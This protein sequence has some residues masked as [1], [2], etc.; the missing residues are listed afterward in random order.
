MYKI[1]L[2][3]LEV[4]FDLQGIN[5]INNVW[6]IIHNGLY[7][8]NKWY[9]I[10]W[11]EEKLAFALLNTLPSIDFIIIDKIDKYKIVLT[12]YSFSSFVS[13]KYI[14]M[15]SFFLGAWFDI[16]I[17]RNSEK[18]NLLCLEDNEFSST[19]TIVSQNIFFM[20]KIAS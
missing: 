8:S 7:H 13:T 4:I 1:C 2:W 6:L 5:I 11:K 14:F 17:H 12:S 18:N 16:D 3:I 9:K 20:K 19:S 15:N 10:Q